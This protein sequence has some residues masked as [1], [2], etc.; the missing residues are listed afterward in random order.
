M[1]TIENLGFEKNTKIVN[2]FKPHYKRG[3]DFLFL[4]GTDFWAGKLYSVA[5]AFKNH[6]GKVY[7]VLTDKSPRAADKD[8]VTADSLTLLK[9]NPLSIGRWHSNGN[10]IEYINIAS[11]D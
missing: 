1:N 11:L 9:L 6:K 8:W 10:E 2:G 5:H 4:I 3:N 7:G